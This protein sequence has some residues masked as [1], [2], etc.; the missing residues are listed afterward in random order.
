MLAVQ[1]YY[2]GVCVKLLEPMTA[3][4]NQRVIVTLKDDWE[5]D[6]PIAPQSEKSKYDLFLDA[7]YCD[8]LVIPT[9]LGNYADEYVRELRANDRL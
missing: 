8:S 5:D 2:D 3:K 4:K 1:G 6:E 7:L 9:E